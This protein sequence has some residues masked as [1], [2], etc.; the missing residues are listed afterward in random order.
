MKLKGN[1][2]V[3]LT[4]D[5]NTTK[6]KKILKKCFLQGQHYNYTQYYGGMK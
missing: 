1:L 4:D 5:D 6:E 2:K 3:T